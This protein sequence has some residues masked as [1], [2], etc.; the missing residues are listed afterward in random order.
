MQMFLQ[1]KKRSG[2]GLLELMVVVLIIGI[3]AAIAIARI[4]PTIADAE[5]LAARRNAQELFSTYTAAAV[6]GIDFVHN[7]PDLLRT[8]E[9]IV[10]GAAVTDTSSPFRGKSFSV[11]GLTPAQ[12]VEASQYLEISSRGMLVY[13]QNRP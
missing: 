5:E 3:A 12:Q 2:Y 10:E 7:D 6:A 4:Q 13:Q 9:R 1:N 11:P 8:I